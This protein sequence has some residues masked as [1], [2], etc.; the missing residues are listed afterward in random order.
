MSGASKRRGI[1]PAWWGAGD[2]LQIFGRSKCG[3]RVKHDWVT[4]KTEYVTTTISTRK[5]AEKWDVPYNTIRDRAIRESWTEARQEFRRKAADRTEQ[6][7]A[8][9][10]CSE[11]AGYIS[12]LMDAANLASRAVY[13]ALSNL[14]GALITKAKDIKD[15]V[16]A[17]KIIH[18]MYANSSE[19]EGMPEDDGLTAAL[20][21]A[22]SEVCSG[23]DDSNLLPEEETDEE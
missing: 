4:I 12:T 13:D 7:V 2:Q 8:D 15:M 14:G 17:I 9:A 6:M 16:D 20:I 21:A 10:I 23:E 18:D 11:S 5:L 22:T 19:A 3:D 1:P